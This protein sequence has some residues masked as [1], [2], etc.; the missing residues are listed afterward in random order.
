MCFVP[1]HAAAK[2][3]GVMNGKATWHLN[4]SNAGVRVSAGPLRFDLAVL[5]KRPASGHHAVLPDIHHGPIC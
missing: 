4:E 1:R 2:Q 3:H 5:A